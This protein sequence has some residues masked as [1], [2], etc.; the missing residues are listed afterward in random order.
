MAVLDGKLGLSL[1]EPSVVTPELSGVLDWRDY[2][3]WFGFQVWTIW[4]CHLLQEHSTGLMVLLYLSV[5]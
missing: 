3:R 5:L 1:Q 4:T 2:D